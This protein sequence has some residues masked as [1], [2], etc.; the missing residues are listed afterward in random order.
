MERLAPL[1]LGM[2]EEAVR[3]IY[4]NAHTD[5][6]RQCCTV[7][8]GHDAAIGCA[9]LF[10]LSVEGSDEFKIYSIRCYT[11]R[12]F[13]PDGFSRLLARCNDWNAGTRW[14][15][16]TLRVFT[17][18]EPPED[19]GQVILEQHVPLPEGAYVD[20][21]ERVYIAVYQAAVDFWKQTT[22]DGDADRDR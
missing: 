5:D 2:I 20:L 1:T 14:P 11:D 6:E 22:A 16:A 18:G 19:R 9:M 15:T 12:S 21:I 13:E 17:D 3:G 10:E 4:G 7:R 8:F